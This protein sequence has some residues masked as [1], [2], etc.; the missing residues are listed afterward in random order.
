MLTYTSTAV[1]SGPFPVCNIEKLGMG[2]G[3]R[4]AQVHN[5]DEHIQTHTRMYT[6]NNYVNILILLIYSINVRVSVNMNMYLHLCM[7][8]LRNYANHSH[9]VRHITQMA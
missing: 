3:T 6:H 7:N 2:L 8:K 9:T 4:P 5:L 1:S